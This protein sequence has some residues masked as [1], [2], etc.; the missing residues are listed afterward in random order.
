M[1]AIGQQWASK[2]FLMAAIRERIFTFSMPSSRLSVPS[3]KPLISG[4]IE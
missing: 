3:L 1:T 2:L 4:F